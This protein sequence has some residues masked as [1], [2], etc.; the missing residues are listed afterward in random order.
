MELNDYKREAIKNLSVI[1]LQ[2]DELS[3][4]G[5]LLDEQKRNEGR[6]L[7][8]IKNYQLELQKRDLEARQRQLQEQN[9]SQT[10]EVQMQCLSD[11]VQM[12]SAK[13]AMLN[14]KI[15]ALET[16]KAAL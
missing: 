3:N 15:G 4:L 9:K 2:K 10:S 6:L 16:Q 12:Q 11:E 13:I 5:S 7:G 8:Q 1:E 14:D